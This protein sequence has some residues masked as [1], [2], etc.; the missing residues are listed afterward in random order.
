M[1]A[2]NRFRWSFVRNVRYWFGFYFLPRFG[3]IAREYCVGPSYDV[4]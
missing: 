3:A 1:A 4:T 2:H